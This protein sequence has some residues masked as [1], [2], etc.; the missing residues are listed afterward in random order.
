MRFRRRKSPPVES[1]YE[2]KLRESQYRKMLETSPSWR[3]IEEELIPLIML[4]GRDGIGSR[5]MKRHMEEFSARYRLATPL[6]LA[7]LDQEIS[8]RFSPKGLD[9]RGE[10]LSLLADAMQVIYS[11]SPKK[12]DYVI[13]DIPDHPGSKSILPVRRP[14][15]R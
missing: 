14:E 1:T 15:T 7:E 12:Y 8:E 13:K 4:R 10:D 2:S 5:I 3:F 9:L 6:T 11:L